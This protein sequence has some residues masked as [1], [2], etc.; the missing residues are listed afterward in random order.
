M[1]LMFTRGKFS[2]IL[3]EMQPLCLEIHPPHSV[4]LSSLFCVSGRESQT[5]QMGERDL[6]PRVLS[7]GTALPILPGEVISLSLSSPQ[8]G[9]PF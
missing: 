2:L 4:V 5:E 9:K 6:Y 7:F 3:T 1:N 8:F